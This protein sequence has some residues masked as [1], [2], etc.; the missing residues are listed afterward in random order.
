MSVAF[1]LGNGI[2]RAGIDLTWLRT[3]GP[4]YGCNALYREF[5][6]DV[7]VATDRPI[8]KQIQDSGYARR[9]VFYTRNPMETSGAKHIPKKYW[10]YSSGPTATA[11]AAENQHSELYLLGFDLGPTT[12]NKFNNIYADTE[13]YKTSQSVPTYTGNWISQLIKVTK[14]F[15]NTQFIRIVGATTASIPDFQTIK[16]FEHRSLAE[17]L[18]Q[19]NNE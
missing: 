11:L 6:P 8:A 2:S 1:V 19:L 16:N 15:P 17:F 7:L 9:N 5:C 10:S 18:K 13:F 4:I 12:N 3:H 14:Q